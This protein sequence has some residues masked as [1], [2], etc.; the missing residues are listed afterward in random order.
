MKVPPKQR[1][2]PPKYIYYPTQPPIGSLVYH[3]PGTISNGAIQNL[4]TFINKE[5]RK[6]ETNMAKHKFEYVDKWLSNEHINHKLSNTF[7]KH[8]VSQPH[9]IPKHS[10][11]TMPNIIWAFT[12][13]NILWPNTHTNSNYTLCP[14]MTKT[15][16]L[17]YSLLY[18]SEPTYQRTK[19]C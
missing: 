3:P 6:R 7:W 5:H 16:S 1:I 8:S 17:T 19:N 4:H 14:I 18:M 10:N 11:L 13:K 12:I 9:I 2:P 15:P